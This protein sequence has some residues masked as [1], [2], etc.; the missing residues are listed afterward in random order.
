VIGF[1]DQKLMDR[2]PRKVEYDLDGF[3]KRK[4]DNR[5]ANGQIRAFSKVLLAG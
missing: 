1:A 2:T 3:W 5:D 4:S